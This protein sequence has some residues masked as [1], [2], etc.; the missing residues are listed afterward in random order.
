MTRSNTPHSHSQ[1]TQQRP[2]Y[3]P[4]SAAQG[5]HT[6]ASSTRSSLARQSNGLHGLP[7]N[8]MNTS[9]SSISTFSATDVHP[10]PSVSRL[11]AHLPSHASPSA[12]DRFNEVDWIINL[13]SRI[14]NALQSPSRILQHAATSSA[15]SPSSPSSYA[16]N[17]SRSRVRLPRP[18]K[19]FRELQHRIQLSHTSSSST[20]PADVSLISSISDRADDPDTSAT[21]WAQHAQQDFEHRRAELQN[22]RQQVL[23]HLQDTR[24]DIDANQNNMH[25]AEQRSVDPAVER[26]ILTAKSLQELM[27]SGGL[28]SQAAEHDDGFDNLLCSAEALPVT[29]HGL[30]PSSLFEAN[31]ASDGSLDIESIL[32]QRA[33]IAAARDSDP[34]RPSIPSSTMLNL[35]QAASNP[36]KKPTIEM[37]G[38]ASPPHSD[39]QPNQAS[40]GHAEQVNEQT[41]H[42]DSDQRSVPHPHP[43]DQIAIVDGVFKIIATQPQQ[44]P[45]HH[46]QTQH[47]QVDDVH[48][49]DNEP[50]KR[51]T[52]HQIDSASDLDA[53]DGTRSVADGEEEEQEEANQEEVAEGEEEEEGDEEEEEEEEEGDDDDEDDDEEEDDDGDG[54]DDGAERRN[55]SHAASLH[56]YDGFGGVNTRDLLFE[57]PIGDADE[58]I[59]LSD[60]DDNSETDSTSSNH[61]VDSQGSQ[62]DQV[63]EQDQ[64]ELVEQSDSQSDSDSNHQDESNQ[65]DIAGSQQHSHEPQQLQ[66][67]LDLADDERQEAKTQSDVDVS[68]AQ[69]EAALQSE[70]NDVL[71]NSVESRIVSG[72]DD[73]LLAEQLEAETQEP[74]MSRPAAVSFLNTASE[75][76]NGQLP[77]DSEGEGVPD[78]EVEPEELDQDLR[79]SDFE[80]A[81][82]QGEDSS[83]AQSPARLEPADLAFRAR[84][85][86]HSMPGFVSAARIFADIQTSE[87]DSTDQASP[88]ACASDERLERID[89]QLLEGFSNNEL[90][91]DLF[92]S[93]H[94]AS[95]DDPQESSRSKVQTE[96]DI[97]DA[98][99]RQD[100]SSDTHDTVDERQL[101]DQEAFPAAAEDIQDTESAI[102][103][104][105]D[106][107]IE[108]PPSKPGDAVS[109]FERGSAAGE[110]DLHRPDTD[111][112]S[113]AAA[114]PEETQNDGAVIKESHD[115]DTEESLTKPGD[116]DSVNEQGAAASEGDD[117][118]AG[119]ELGKDAE[120]KHHASLPSL[121]AEKMVGRQ[122]NQ[123]VDTVEQVN[124][125]HSDAK[126]APASREQ[127]GVSQFGEAEELLTAAPVS[128]GDKDGSDATIEKSQASLMC[129]ESTDVLEADV[130]DNSGNEAAPDAAILQLENGPALVAA[131]DASS[132]AE[133]NTVEADSNTIGIL[134]T[135][136]IVD[137]P[138]SVNSEPLDASVALE[139][140]EPHV[141]V[142]VP[143][144]AIHETEKEATLSG[145]LT[146]RD[147]SLE[148]Q[149][150]PA[151]AATLSA[152][153][154][155]STAQGDAAQVYTEVKADVDAAALVPNPSEKVSSEQ[156]KSKD[157][158]LAKEDADQLADDQGGNGTSPAAKVS[159]HQ[160]S[161]EHNLSS[162]VANEQPTF[163]KPEQESKDIDLPV[164]VFENSLTPRRVPP[165][166]ASSDRRSTSSF[167][168]SANRQGNRH[169]HGAAKRN[170]FAQVTEAA[171]GLASNLAAPLRALP[172]LL[173]I[174]ERRAE[175]TREDNEKAEHTARIENKME[176]NGREEERQQKSR[177]N[178]STELPKF[179]ITTRSHCICRRLQLSKVEGAPI[180]IVP[181]CSINYEQAHK[182][183]A[184]D[185]GL[186][187]E[188]L[189]DD[190]LTVDPDLIPEDVHHTLS[191]I[192]G[193]EFLNEGICVEPD[194]TAAKLVFSG[195]DL[196]VD[197]LPPLDEEA[198]HSQ[199]M[200]SDDTVNKRD[201]DAKVENKTGESAKNVENSS[202]EAR[203]END[204]AHTRTDSSEGNNLEQEPETPTRAT[205]RSNRHRRN[206]SAA[207]ASSH[208]RSPR[209]ADP[210]SPNADYLPEEERRRLAKHRHPQAVVSGDVS[211]ASLE[212]QATEQMAEDHSSKVG[213][214]KEDD[215]AEVH[216]PPAPPAAL[217]SQ[218]KKKRGRP[219]K[220][221]AKD[222]QDT[223]TAQHEPRANEVDLDLPSSP[224]LKKRRG[225]KSAASA[226]PDAG[227][228]PIN[229]DEDE[230]DAVAVES[231]LDAIELT[232]KRSLRGGQTCEEKAELK[233]EGDAE[234]NHR[235][236][237]DRDQLEPQQDSKRKAGRGRKKRKQPSEENSV[238]SLREE[239]EADKKI[240]KLDQADSVKEIHT[241]RRSRGG[242]ASQSPSATKTSPRKSLKRKVLKLN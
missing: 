34:S 68:D 164:S 35:S 196:G 112:D 138:V 80:P 153:Q 72:F 199:G 82:Q 87:A 187:D 209:H 172:S 69:Q 134:N 206:S 231:A 216:A 67:P 132:N 232:P 222:A 194:S 97:F 14:G 99:T 174:S 104:D 53:S 127:M 239:T 242:A 18:S 43:M 131:A 22:S 212:K 83:R 29:N 154:E 88:P 107:A 32:R 27:R 190:W 137:A 52:N 17:S 230:H 102:E 214:I 13:S 213:T 51:T 10:T 229:E 76:A 89:P 103:E 21:S 146:D 120:T 141:S 37:L 62:D 152:I 30:G 221:A 125:S 55:T 110:A 147:S 157:T 175:E 126:E 63:E 207:S 49:Q 9:S 167:T 198:S 25:T 228:A 24:T 195:F 201:L 189:A 124:A 108:V 170:F 44:L 203:E 197:L 100:A 160:G 33:Q 158:A 73:G 77:H 8:N 74:E 186:T 168:P 122:G 46:T 3:V 193:L 11:A 241:R 84:V 42:L 101:Q 70:H 178:N 115:A 45:Q 7:Q 75:R 117:V 215:Q 93:A 47:V 64:D 86:A 156:E 226:A 4:Y 166:P 192:I 36:N 95:N 105:H 61:Q 19:E 202:D 129:I 114:A 31:R 41:T 90:V 233:E 165:S 116:V 211:I 65:G 79:W 123:H 121:V 159:H 161:T 176:G 50:F 60:S 217:P 92:S 218:S 144:E 12:Y 145:H 94:T 113:P 39:P 28:Q 40:H 91:T 181:G 143:E 6:N 48:V 238:A 223:P 133:A 142:H 85:E 191:R 1:H 136:V 20:A 185:L 56:Y 119:S 135:D 106:A 58:P 71:N 182:E 78:S 5:Q 151:A 236:N 208:H 23:K 180:F 15:A 171:S 59:V 163:S 109:Y 2:Y 148:R 237:E 57:T 173:P 184:E 111:Q 26:S 66:N 235:Q 224:K 140:S 139:A 234:R 130:Q 98:F 227:E 204:S 188:S 149:V 150:A 169:L 96:A 155:H 128:V 118:L 183:G 177:S 200:G 38:D 240:P 205:R 179:T 162:D 219:R 210:K 220:S 16:L 81:Q 225:H 54:M